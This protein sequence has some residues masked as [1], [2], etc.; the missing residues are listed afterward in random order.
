MW[1]KKYSE[2]SNVYFQVREEMGGGNICVETKS[3]YV[4][5]I[6]CSKIGQWT[7][8]TT[9]SPEF[10]NKFVS[11]L[12]VIDSCGMP[13][14]GETKKCE[15]YYVNW[16]G[17][18]SNGNYG[19]YGSLMQGKGQKGAASPAY[20]NP[21]GGL[22]TGWDM[23]KKAVLL[24]DGSVIYFG[25]HATGFISV[26]VNSFGKGPNVLGRDLF[27][28]MVNEDWAKPLGAEGTFNPSANGKTCECSKDY[29]IERGQGF[30][31]S[32]DL[33]N[34]QMLSGACCSATKL[35]K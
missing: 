10:V 9:L 33:L 7:R 34:S 1:K 21:A 29:G 18:C 12:K 4:N 3:G 31:G 22:Y 2:I 25:G 30:L 32:A 23:N 5:S 27:T 16:V 19:Y 8:Y 14:Y 17:F 6:K 20:C 11:H 24:A 15:N 28:V 26:D 35:S 13:E